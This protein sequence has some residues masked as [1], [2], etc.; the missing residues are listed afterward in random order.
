MSSSGDRPEVPF[1]TTDQMREVDR[2]MEEEYGILLLQMMES[3][4][5]NLAH[6]A[7]LRFLNGDPR[8]RR[9]LVLAGTG[10]NG[11]GGLVCARWLQN[12][13]ANVRVYLTAPAPQLA[14]VP[15]HQHTILERMSIPMEVVGSDVRL[16]PADLVVDAIIGYSLRGAPRGA[17]AALI[18]AANDHGAPILSLDVPSGVDTTTGDVHDPAMEAAATLTLALPK[19]GLRSPAAREQI[20]ELYLADIGVPPALYKRLFLDLNVGP[21]FA[22]DDIVRLG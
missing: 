16:A 19:Q 12:W 15:R 6:L 2:A 4:G 14:D 13:G 7:R 1:I 8:G 22:T 10:G 11:G 9:V 17:A 21:I 20:G 18:R 5:R 3:A